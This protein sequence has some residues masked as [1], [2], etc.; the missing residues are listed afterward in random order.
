M[1]RLVETKTALHGSKRKFTSCWL[2]KLLA[3]IYPF[4]RLIEILERD[5]NKIE[6]MKLEEMS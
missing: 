1:I 2:S 4:F 5:R 6:L 3:N